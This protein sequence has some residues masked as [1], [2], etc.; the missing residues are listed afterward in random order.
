MPK[1]QV[2]AELDKPLTQVVYIE[3]DT[4][5][6]AMDDTKS[7]RGYDTPAIAREYG[8]RGAK[9]LFKCTITVELVGPM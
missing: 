1:E 7:Y 9:Y 3:G 2:D 5:Q 8:Q 6:V 4:R